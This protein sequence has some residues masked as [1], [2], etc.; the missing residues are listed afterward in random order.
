M[1]NQLDGDEDAVWSLLLAA[2]YLKVVEKEKEKIVGK[3]QMYTLALT[4][5]EV[6][7]MF[8]GI[9]RG[10]FSSVSLQQNKM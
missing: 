9:V 3:P 4:N 2:G 10:W 7:D 6:F 1:Y 8:C 5:G